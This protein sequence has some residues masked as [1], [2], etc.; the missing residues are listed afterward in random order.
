[1]ENRRIISLVLAGIA[2]LVVVWTCIP[3]SYGSTAY[4][5]QRVT[6]EYGQLSCG[7]G[8]VGKPLIFSQAVRRNAFGDLSVSEENLGQDHVVVALYRLGSQGWEAVSMAPTEGGMVVLMK[9]A[10]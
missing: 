8:G 5:A 2:V 3:S 7:I 10:R 9:R 4:S 6:W 1:M